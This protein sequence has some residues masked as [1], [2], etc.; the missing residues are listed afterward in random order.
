MFSAQVWAYREQSGRKYFEVFL[1]NGSRARID[2]LDSQVVPP[3]LL[4]LVQ[5]PRH[6]LA[7]TM[8]PPGAAPSTTQSASPI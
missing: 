6:G 7:P 8:A 2:F 3:A 1:N 5:A 4:S